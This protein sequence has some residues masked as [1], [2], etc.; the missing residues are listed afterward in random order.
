[1]KANGL[2]VAPESVP[3]RTEPSGPRTSGRRPG[4]QQDQEQ[5]EDVLEIER[6]EVQGEAEEQH[7]CANQKEGAQALS[8][9]SAADEPG[10]ATSRK[11]TG[12]N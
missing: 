10:Q 7:A 3:P 12:Q 1:M 8:G 9:G 6:D 4:A 11:A 2:R 5:R